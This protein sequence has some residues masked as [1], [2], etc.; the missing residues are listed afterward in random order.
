[1]GEHWPTEDGVCAKCGGSGRHAVHGGMFG[2]QTCPRCD[3]TG[4]VDE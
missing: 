4:E 3:G 1:M 2:F